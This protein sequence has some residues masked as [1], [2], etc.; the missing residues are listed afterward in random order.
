VRLSDLGAIDVI[1]FVQRQATRL[2]QKRAKM[3]TTALRSFLRYAL[4]LGDI[5]IDLTTAVPAVANWTMT[6]IPRAIAAAD[7]RAVL[8]RCKRDTAT[9]C[10]DFAILLLLAR[11]GLRSGEVRLLTLDNIDWETGSINITGKGGK[12]ARLPLP[13]DVG[14]AIVRYLQQGRPASSCRA[15]FLRS[16]APVVAFKTQQGIGDVVKHALARAGI[17]SPRHGAHQFRHGLACEM[18]RQGATLTEIGQLLRHSNPQITSIY[19][20]ADLPALRTL[21][22]PW[23]EKI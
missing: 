9:G 14:E 8:A 7:V 23:P 5:Q 4:Y 21:S 17:E 16:R 12:P 10:R 20:K 6:S 22:L 15:L 1:R 2:S 3:M 18:L 19:A 13:V 11:L